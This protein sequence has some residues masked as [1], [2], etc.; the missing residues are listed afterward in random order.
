LRP[1]EP[2]RSLIGALVRCPSC[3]RRTR[4]SSGSGGQK[5]A[6]RTVEDC[7][8]RSGGRFPFCTSELE[9]V[10][11]D[12][13]YYSTVVVVVVVEK[14]ERVRTGI[15]DCS[16]V[17]CLQFAVAGSDVYREGDRVK[18]LTVFVQ[19]TSRVELS[20]Q[21]GLIIPRH[22]KAAFPTRRRVFS[23]WVSRPAGQPGRAGGRVVV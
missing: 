22:G 4:S 8:S 17:T 10:G 3:R 7:A 6:S 12:E 2:H 19:R 11:R 13:E 5:I 16:S 1:H 15:L 18:L 9:A 20:K 14:G 21:V 23:V